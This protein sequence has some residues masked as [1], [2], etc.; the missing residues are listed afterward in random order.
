MATH[1]ENE[2]RFALWMRNGRLSFLTWLI[3]LF[4]YIGFRLA[5]IE[6]PAITNTLIALTGVLV[7][8]LG[9]AQGQR[10]A[11]QEQRAKST[12][13]KVDDLEAGAE[14]SV[15]RAEAAERRE[16]GWSDHLDHESDRAARK[17]GG[18]DE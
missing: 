16:H 18:Q 9:I 17:K 15:R 8:N 2:S 4:A 5:G 6:D 13:R 10:V 11:K 3:V 1:D 14:L 12:A 7:G